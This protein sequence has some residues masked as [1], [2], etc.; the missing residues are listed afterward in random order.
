LDAASYTH[1][2]T[3]VLANG[4][5]VTGFS[6]NVQTD[7]LASH[8]W[9]GLLSRLEFKQDENFKYTLGIQLRYFK[10]KLQEKVRDLLGGDF[11]IDDYAWAADG[12]AGR[13][14]IKT[15]GDIIKV[16]NGAINPS[17]SLF[18]QVEYEKGQTNAFLSGTFTN[19]WYQRYDNYNYVTDTR[20]DVILKTGFDLKAGVNQRMG[21][22]HHVF[23]NGGYFSRAPYFKYVFGGFTNVQ[24]KDLEN[25][26]VKAF[27]VGY[28]FTGSLTRFRVNYYYTY[29]ED[30]SF[31]SN[32]YIQLED[33]TQVQSTPSCLFALT[34]SVNVHTLYN[35]LAF[36]G[37]VN[38]RDHVD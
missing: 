26:K 31:L 16:D 25:E 15:V 18:G 7:F 1:T 13:N 19:M 35:N 14:E 22:N 6:K 38:T 27:E 20:S 36:G 3:A 23:A 33:N 8:H 32:E 10:S 9:G 4:E 30:K 37:A 34:H 24:T 11:F 17:S 21:E 2:D 28:G 12:L 5:K 29:W